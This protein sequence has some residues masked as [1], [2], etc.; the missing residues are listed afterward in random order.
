MTPNCTPIFCKPRPVPYAM[1]ERIEEEID[2]LIREKIIEPVESNEWATPVVPVLK[3]NGKIRLCGDY[4]ITLNPSL[5]I[6]RHPIPRVQDLIAR[7]GDGKI[8]T[9]LDLAQAYQQVELDKDSKNLTV[10][11][12]HKGLFRPNRLFYGIASAPGLFQREMEQIL[13]SINGVVVYFD[14]VLISGKTREEHDK[15]LCEVLERFEKLGLTVRREKCVFAQNRVSFLGYDLD[16]EGIHVSE[17]RI[18]AIQGLREP[19][20]VTELKSVLGILTYYAKFVKNYAQ[21]A[22]PL[23]ELLRK[24]VKWQWS[25]KHKNAFNSLKKC[26]ASPEV[27]IPYDLELPVKVTC[28]ASPDGLGAVLSH[29]LPGHRERP[30]AFASRT[31]NAAERNYSQFDREALAI[32]FAIRSFHQYIYGREFDLETDHK[33]LIYI[34]GE[35]KGLPQM[36]ASRVQRWAVFLS[37]Y[38]FKIKHIKG[39]ENV[40]ADV[41]SRMSRH[42]ET[43][44]DRLCV[45][46]SYLN[47]VCETNQNIDSEVVKNETDKDVILSKVK[48]FIM[49]GWPN[50]IDDEL[51]VFKNRQLELTVEN[52]CIMRGH[53]LV[54]PLSLRSI[55]L[56]ELHEAHMG[57]VKMKALARSYVWWPLIDKDLENVTKSCTLCLR[58]AD[59]P[60][61]MVLHPWK[62]P[63]SANDRIHADFC[64]PIHKYMYL[65]ITDAHSKWV[66]IYELTDITANSTIRVMRRYF[67]TWGI[68]K[69]LVTDNGPTFT[70]GAFQE[71]IEKNGVKHCLTAPY[72]PASNG[73]AENAVRTFKN[74]FKMLLES[75]LSREEALCKYLF[76]YRTT[77]H[78]S[79]GVTPAELQIGRKLR[80][81]LDALKPS[82][83]DKTEQQQNN[84]KRY[85]SGN[86]SVEFDNK[87]IVM[88]KDYSK[89]EWCKA[90]VVDKLGPVTYTVHTEDERLWK[91]HSDQMRKCNLDMEKC[92][93]SENAP[94][95]QPLIPIC[96]KQQTVEINDVCENTANPIVKATVNQNVNGEPTVNKNRE[97]LIKTPVSTLRRSQRTIRKPD[98]LDL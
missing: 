57:I 77:P 5:I 46:Y 90:R 81:R 63:E 59:N 39:K 75:K 7:I 26:L 83:Y 88:T 32:V 72:H 87:E 85:F 56:R 34:F 53:R 54:V 24:E 25:H 61:R 52:G 76:Y 4:K 49:N 93:D 79:T 30:V 94:N 8:F 17:D 21:L 20:N 27:L 16:G 12:T 80:T 86:R 82:V 97:S 11:T 40:P 15:R 44:C 73:S 74:K 67:C 3:T 71:F 22:N 2:R 9:K 33:P 35:K 84:Q 42:G 45:E 29:V 96:N 14:D 68:P 66:D 38:N 78:C 1:R 13:N 98:R 55:I 48:V 41:L 70:S 18:K 36:A 62:Y 47:F 65:V 28:D 95:R 19:N 92:N 58:N 37:G 10:I 43:K 6:D 51:K 69:M 89:G 60:P 23:Y 31:L 50:A 64:G 91:R